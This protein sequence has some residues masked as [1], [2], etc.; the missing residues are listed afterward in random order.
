MYSAETVVQI[1]LGRVERGRLRDLLTVDVQG[2]PIARLHGRDVTPAC[3]QGMSPRRVAAGCECKH[4]AGGQRAA[5]Y[6]AIVLGHRPGAAIPD[7]RRV[8]EPGQPLPSCF[9]PRTSRSRPEARCQRSS[10]RCGP[11]C[12]SL[13][14]PRPTG[15]RP[16]SGRRL[17]N[18]TRV[19][20]ARSRRRAA[21]GTPRT[22]RFACSPRGVPYRSS[23]CRR[24][25]RR[26]RRRSWWRRDGRCTRPGQRPV[27]LRSAAGD[28]ARLTVVAKETRRSIQRGGIQSV[29]EHDHAA[30]RFRVR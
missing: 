23:G 15:R 17:R 29:A 1:E 12:P 13:P 25:G 14:I 19:R 11:A 9:A 22:N 3:G 28:P 4:L 24:S 21:P 6:P 5:E 16:S 26:G 27:S 2:Q 7:V 10:G 18:D 20:W 30:D 8:I